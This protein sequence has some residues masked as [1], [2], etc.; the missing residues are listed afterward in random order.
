MSS[1]TYFF[2]SY[3]VYHVPY[4]TFMKNAL[5]VLS[6]VIFKVVCGSHFNINNLE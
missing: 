2:L 4:M 3:L 1:T 5:S 6:D